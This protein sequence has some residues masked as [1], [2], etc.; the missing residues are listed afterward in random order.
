[1]NDERPNAKPFRHYRG[2][3]SIE[4]LGRLI[5]LNCYPSDEIGVLMANGVIDVID[6][7]MNLPVPIND[8]HLN[9]LRHAVNMMRVTVPIVEAPSFHFNSLRGASQRVEAALATLRADL[10]KMIDF[11]REF[12]GK[13]ATQSAEVFETVLAAA[14]DYFDQR[15]M[16]WGGKTPARRH[17]TWHDDAVY[18]A[19][20]LRNASRGEL[21]TSYPTA[22]AVGFID[23]ALT[24]ANVKHGDRGAIARHLA[25]YEADT[26]RRIELT[27]EKRPTTSAV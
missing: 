23:E 10:P 5:F 15:W 12:D 6:L 4:P 8:Q 20:L 1:M 3:L 16:A 25:R 26:K 22:P 24:R 17:E 27:L 7:A 18:L 21:A 9:E 14:G 11:H 2:E 19:F 13:R